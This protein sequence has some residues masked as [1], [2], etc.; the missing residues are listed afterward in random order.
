[1]EEASWSYAERITCLL[2]TLEAGRRIWKKKK[3]RP[4]QTENIFITYRE[5][6]PYCIYNTPQYIAPPF[7]SSS[8]NLSS[9]LYTNSFILASYVYYVLLFYFFFLEA[10]RLAVHELTTYLSFFFI[11]FRFFYPCSAA[12]RRLLIPSLKINLRN[13]VPIE[14]I[15]FLF[16]VTPRKRPDANDEKEI[17]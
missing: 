8:A 10:K 7:N 3:K 11:I 15:S 2:Q 12:K 9:F 1:M 13:L 14:G 4:I 16:W 6:I 17:D 5:K